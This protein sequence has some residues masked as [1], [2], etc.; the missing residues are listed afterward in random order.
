MTETNTS[1]P[2]K[3][4]LLSQGLV[5]GLGFLLFLIVFFADKTNLTNEDGATIGSR[6]M[7]EN[8]APTV[9]DS[10][11]LRLHP[12]MPSWLDELK[13]RKGEEKLPILD[14]IIVT[15]RSENRFAVAADFAIQRIAID[16][17]LSNLWAVARLS[18]QAANM[19][20]VRRDTALMGKYVRRSITFASEILKVEP[21]NEE[22]LMILGMGLINSG[23][24]NSM[25]GILTIR[26]ILEINPDNIEA[27]YQLGMFSIQTSQFDKAQQRFERVLELD[28]SRNDA[29]LQLAYVLLQLGSPE[30]ASILL[31]EIISEAAESELKTMAEELKKSIK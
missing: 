18:Q 28:P 25:Q 1:Y 3:K 5:L 4:H 13:S 23:G 7:V 20:F 10:L 8:G 26:K 6:E 27:S 12:N 9:N 17:S 22:G 30:K 19:D 31:D 15:L 29:K 14:S 11:I 21:D 16:S 2:K 24:R